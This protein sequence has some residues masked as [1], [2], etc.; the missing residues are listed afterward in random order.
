MPPAAAE[1]AEISEMSED[2]GDR[3]EVA[4]PAA[5]RLAVCT[6]TGAWEAAGAGEVAGVEYAVPDVAGASA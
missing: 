1:V 6:V 2:W 5:G 3:L 4:A